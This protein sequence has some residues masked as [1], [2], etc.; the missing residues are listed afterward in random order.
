MDYTAI[1]GSRSMGI[2]LEHSDFDIV[3]T[4]KQFKSEEYNPYHI[5]G[6]RA[7]RQLFPL[8]L[9]LEQPQPGNIQQLYPFKFL[10][11]NDISRYILNNRERIIQDNL[12]R[13]YDVYFDRAKSLQEVTLETFAIKYPKRVV[14]SLIYLDTLY[15][16]ATQ[17]ISFEEAFRP[18]GEFKQT[19]MSIRKREKKINVLSLYN[20][21]MGK[22]TS[23]SKFYEH[24]NLD[25]INKSIKDFGD[26]LEIKIDLL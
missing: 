25:G 7:N 20:D 13:L 10:E 12:S 18:N 19:I 4:N 5:V 23:V 11:E 17:D 22:A 1:V 21:L 26:M 16:F 6:P 8:S 24:R 3:T 9:V 14:Y 2:E 15:R